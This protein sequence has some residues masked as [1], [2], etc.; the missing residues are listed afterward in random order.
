[1]LAEEYVR[2]NVPG[3]WDCLR[4]Y[5]PSPKW[6]VPLSQGIEWG[7]KHDHY[8]YADFRMTSKVWQMES[9]FNIV[10]HTTSGYRCPIGN[11][12]VGGVDGSR[13]IEGRAYDFVVLGPRWTEELKEEIVDWVIVNGG[14]A[15]ASEKGHVHV[16]W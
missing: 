9:R 13:H 10:A 7:L 11:S 1:M 6:V 14:Y 2:E 12:N 16:S 8:G 15:Y 3:Y 4:F 5:R